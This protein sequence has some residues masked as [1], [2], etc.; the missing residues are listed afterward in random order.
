MISSE[1]K[2]T[3]YI[4][5][6]LILAAAILGLG[7]FVLGIRS[8]MA[9]TRNQ[10]VATQQ[11]LE[12]YYKFNKYHGQILYGEDVMACIREFAGTDIAVYVKNLYGKSG[13]SAYYLNKKNYLANSNIASIDFLEHGK[14]SP[15][16]VNGT[17]YTCTKGVKRDV[18]YYAYVVFSEYVDSNIKNAK[19]SDLTSGISYSDVTAI[20]IIFLKNGRLDESDNTVKTEIS[21][22]HAG[23]KY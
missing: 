6:S 2:E 10:E 9:A 22:I 12:D 1:I 20:K 18:T 7:A 3:I 15:T 23:T 14:N 17:T 16:T 5:I 13:N 21:K 19:Y 11:S 8:D 4:A